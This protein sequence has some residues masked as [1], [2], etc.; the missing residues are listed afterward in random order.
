MDDFFGILDPAEP[1][2]LTAPVGYETV[3][4]EGMSWA[5][6]GQRYEDT[7]RITDRQWN[8]L[9]AQFRGLA[10]LPGV[11]VDDVLYSSPMLLRDFIARAIIATLTGHD[12]PAYGLLDKATYDPDNNGVI[13]LANGG[14]GIAAASNAALLAALGAAALA[15]P[16]LTGVPTAP[17]AAPG[18]N[19]LQIATTAF[20]KAAIDALIAAAPGALDTLDELASA[21]GDDA[22]FAATI[23]AL[24]A[25]KL[26][27]D[28]NLNDLPNKATA[29]SNLGADDA[30]NLTTGTIPDARVSATLAADKAFRRG[31]IIGTAS[32]AAGVPTGALVEKGVN[33]NGWYTRFADGTQLC[34][35]TPVFT[36]TGG[37]YAGASG[38]FAAAFAGTVSDIKIAHGVSGFTTG[39]TSGF[40]RIGPASLTGWNGSAIA[41]SNETLTVSALAVGRWF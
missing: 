21:L 8:H 5:R 22:N 17:T 25:T 41:N 37:V 39:P 15:G 19:T 29:R 36:I 7:T 18:T 38:N 27:K 1:R 2:T 40:A 6:S 32:Q 11:N 16:A 4:Q 35:F 3:H 13:G 31:N 14:T 30:A 34:W 28:Q 33:A 10:T 24:I 9:I 20:V 23:T 26:Q 12:I